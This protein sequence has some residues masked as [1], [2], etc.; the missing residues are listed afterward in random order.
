MGGKAVRY[1][2]GQSLLQ[3]ELGFWSIMETI[4]PHVLGNIN[5][6]HF[7]TLLESINT[8]KATSFSTSHNAVRVQPMISQY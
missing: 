3:S 6:K 8:V 7:N 4:L 5:T 2:T 1:P